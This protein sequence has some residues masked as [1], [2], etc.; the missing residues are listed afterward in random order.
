MSLKTLKMI[1][2]P[3]IAKSMSPICIS[4]LSTSL[5]KALVMGIFWDNGALV[6]FWQYDGNNHKW[7]GKIGLVL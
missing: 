1:K 5:S 3:D 7:V 2:Y 4:I 6:L